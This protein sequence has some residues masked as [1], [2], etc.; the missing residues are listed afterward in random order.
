MSHHNISIDLQLLLHE[1]VWTIWGEAMSRMTIHKNVRKS[2]IDA[3][4]AHNNQ[5]VTSNKYKV[6]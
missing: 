3:G 2:T 1:Q 5:D 4:D 6:T